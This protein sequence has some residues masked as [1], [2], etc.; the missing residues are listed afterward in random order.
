[1]SLDTLIKKAKFNRA[2]C[3]FSTFCV[4]MVITTAHAHKSGAIFHIFPRAFKQKKI[5]A[6]RPKKTKIASRGSCLKKF[7]LFYACLAN[8]GI[9]L[10]LRLRICASGHLF[11]HCIDEL[12]FFFA[13]L[14]PGALPA[15]KLGVLAAKIGARLLFFMLLKSATRCDLYL[16][17]YIICAIEIPCDA[18]LF[19]HLPPY[20][21]FNSRC[22]LRQDP[23]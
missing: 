18:N 20:V 14:A 23:P 12:C 15:L 17:T 19:Y 21:F 2:R 13:L 9:F 3:P 4:S 1:M 7:S 5:K 8:V 6:L 11:L 10:H 16:L 22:Y